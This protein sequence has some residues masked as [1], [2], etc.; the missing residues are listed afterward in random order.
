MRKYRAIAKRKAGF[1]KIDWCAKEALEDKI[2]Y[3]WVDTC[4]I[5]KSSSAELSEAIN[6]MFRWY[7]NSKICYA[8]L[9]DVPALPLD[10][11]GWLKGDWQSFDLEVPQFIDEIPVY[12]DE[13]SKSTEAEMPQFVDD[14][15]QFEDELSDR[16]EGLR[17]TVPGLTKDGKRSLTTKQFAKI[18]V[19]ARWLSRGWTLQELIAPRLLIF[20]S[21]DWIEI[22][23]KS[24]RSPCPHYQC[25]SSNVL[26]YHKESWKRGNSLTTPLP[27]G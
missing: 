8:Y 13:A 4:Y 1:R 19:K 15:P 18:F 11:G 3:I 6:S 20:F 16:L 9:S 10:S 24:E 22:G 14:H 12:K 26:A 23:S 2:D 7:R 17:S 27:S 25:L 21:K 5:N